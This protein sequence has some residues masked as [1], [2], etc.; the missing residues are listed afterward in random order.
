MLKKLTYEIRSKPA[1]YS[2]ILV[3]HIV[4]TSVTWRDIRSRRADQVR[5]PKYLW[6]TASALNM[7]NSLAYFCLGRKRID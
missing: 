2:G 5:G 1:L 7:S 6:R 4:V 3:A